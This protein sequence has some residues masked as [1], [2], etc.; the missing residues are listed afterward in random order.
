MSERAAGCRVT[1]VNEKVMKVFRI[2]R[3]A[4]AGFAVVRDLQFP[5]ALLPVV[6]PCFPLVGR[7]FFSLGRV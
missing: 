5:D 2:L 1:S 3:R 7:C 6:K 4:R